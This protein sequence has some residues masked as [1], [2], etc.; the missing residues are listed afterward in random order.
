[1]ERFC[2]PLIK[3]LRFL[4]VNYWLNLQNAYDALIAEFDSEKELAEERNIF[5]DLDYKYFKDNFGL[6]D[7]PRRKDEQI[8]KVREFLK[9]ATL[10]VLAKRDMTTA[11]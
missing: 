1:M 10:S 6:P 8:K 7:L 5:A 3:R 11:S 2:S 4:G 9:V